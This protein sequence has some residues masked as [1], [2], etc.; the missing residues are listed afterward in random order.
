M[1][2][3]EGAGS[4]G[5]VVGLIGGAIDQGIAAHARGQSW[6]RQKKIL[7]N[8]I[9]W[10]MRDMRN[11]GI[12]PILAAGGSFSGVSGQVSGAQTPSGT[13]SAL[14]AGLGASARQAKVGP[15]RKK[16]SAEKANIDANTGLANSAAKV[17]I[18]REQTERAMQAYYEAL[19]TQAYAGAD[20][21]AAEAANLRT[22]LPR[23]QAEEDE[24]RAH[25]RTL[26][27]KQQA[28]E[29]LRALP[30]GA[31]M[32]IPLGGKR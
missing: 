24:W 1:T 5:P 4:W 2:G 12:N 28:E 16:L 10:R 17:N 19:G 22:L 20:R 21:Q 15:E 32:R 3:G 26:F 13:G 14:A 7:Q 8:Q 11:A 23:L 25:G 30:F 29:L 27:Y 18:Q 31:S 6:S 9:F